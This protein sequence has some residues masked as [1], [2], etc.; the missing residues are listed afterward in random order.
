MR[1]E[2]VSAPLV[3]SF[4]VPDEPMPGDVVVELGLSDVVPVGPVEPVEPVPESVLL[5]GVCASGV[6]VAPGEVVV[7]GEFI[8]LS[9]PGVV[10]ERP[11]VSVGVVLLGAVVE[12]LPGLAEPVPELPVPLDC[13]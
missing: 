9:L 13:A 8:V 10:C 5:L 12:G 7:P 4:V 2:R 1:P 6:G 11:V 3:E